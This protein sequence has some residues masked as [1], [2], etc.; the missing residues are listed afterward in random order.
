M[1]S[2]HEKQQHAS[3]SRIHANELGSIIIHIR[4]EKAAFLLIASEHSLLQFIATHLI[5][6]IYSL[7]YT[8]W[9]LCCQE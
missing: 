6:L 7:I 5:V 4:A 9:L 3:L 2:L 1:C 8:T